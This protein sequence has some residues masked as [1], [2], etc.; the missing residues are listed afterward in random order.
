MPARL[1]LC[2]TVFLW[3]AFESHF[4][5]AFFAATVETSLADIFGGIQE[6]VAADHA[7]VVAEHATPVN[8]PTLVGWA[9]TTEDQSF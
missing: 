4:S 2:A 1:T 7:A 8:H 6:A 3:L 9:A 5:P